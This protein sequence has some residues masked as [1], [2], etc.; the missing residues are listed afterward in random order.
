VDTQNL[1]AFAAF[2]PINGWDPYGLS[3]QE[4]RQFLKDMREIGVFLPAFGTLIEEIPADNA[5]LGWVFFAGT[6][7]FGI[8]GWQPDLNS[9]SLSSF[10]RAGLK[11][12]RDGAAVAT[13]GEELTHAVWDVLD[14][15]PK[16]SEV[17]SRAIEHYAGRRLK[18]GSK[19][20]DPERVAD[21]AVAGYVGARLA[22]YTRLL[23]LLE[24]EPDPGR[25]RELIEKF[26]SNPEATQNHGYQD[27]DG[28]QK[29]VEGPLPDF[30]RKFAD[31][32]ILKGSFSG[33]MTNSPW[34][35]QAV[36]RGKTSS[37]SSS[38]S[39]GAQA[40]RESGSATGQAR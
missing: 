40:P 31:D 16:Y 3:S 14:V 35:H 37:T 29:R 30:L 10:T 2:D 26:D 20:T 33:P 36:E 17:K 27:D 12:L 1:Y 15:V 22:A 5:F 39:G 21:E 19:V 4:L 18:D 25:Q 24:V 11:N 9:L 23:R 7:I 34:L 8:D 38:D 13:V 6:D 32:E 28:V